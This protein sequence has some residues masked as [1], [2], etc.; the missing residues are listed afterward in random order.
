MTFKEILKIPADRRVSVYRAL[1]ALD[2][3][4]A[5][6]KNKVEV[7]SDT[8]PSDPDGAMFA[9]NKLMINWFRDIAESADRQIT[10]LNN[11]AEDETHNI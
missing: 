10:D 1:A 3:I 8:L 7:L 2:I 5:S 9:N 11:H 6:A 4:R